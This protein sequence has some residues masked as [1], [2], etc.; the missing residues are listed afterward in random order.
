MPQAQGTASISLTG[1]T[2]GDLTS[3][4]GLTRQQ[5]QKS[6]Q[7]PLRD[8]PPFA[9]A[10]FG[11]ERSLGCLRV[12][13]GLHRIDAQVG[14]KAECSA[15]RLDAC[16]V[17][18]SGHRRRPPPFRGMN[19]QLCLP[20]FFSGNKSWSNSL[21]VGAWFGFNL[22]RVTPMSLQS[23]VV[24]LIHCL[25]SLSWRKARRISNPKYP[26]FVLTKPGEIPRFRP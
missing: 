8:R 14:S 9:M 18:I 26:V 7:D 5:S 17:P 24:Y 22:T 12:R 15:R 2:G 3:T 19:H 11:T 23:S 20:P 6:P 10:A 1:D 4:N 25:S 13:H 16:F 21:R